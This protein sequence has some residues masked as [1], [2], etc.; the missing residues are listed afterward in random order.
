MNAHLLLVVFCWEGEMSRFKNNHVLA[1]RV[2][3]EVERRALDRLAERRKQTLSE[4]LRGLV[5][6]AL[7]EELDLDQS[8]KMQR[9]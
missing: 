4:F 5:R 3:N 1:F 6:R 2:Q 9:Y 7:I 8:R